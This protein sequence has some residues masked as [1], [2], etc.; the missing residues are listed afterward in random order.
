MSC[1]RLIVVLLGCSLA[2]AQSVTSASLKTS[3]DNGTNMTTPP[4]VKDLTAPE[5]LP[6]RA[7]DFSKG[8]NPET[9]AWE[10]LTQA[11]E[12]GRVG[13]RS[14]ATHALGLLKNNSRARILAEKG[15]TDDKPQVRAAAAEALG[16]MGARKSIPKLR[17]SL[18]DD[19]PSVALAAA[20]SLYQMHDRSSYEVYYEVLTRQRKSNKGLIAS[21]LATLEDPKKMAQLGFEEGIG[22]VPFA[23]I[24]WSAYKE[25]KK[26]DSSPVRAA[27]ARMLAEDPDPA[28]TVTL[29]KE[30]GDSSWIVRAAAVDALARRG[31]PKAL[32]TVESR[33]SDEKDVVSYTAAAATLRLL[34]AK[35]IKAAGKP[36]LKTSAAAEK[37]EPKTSTP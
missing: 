15:L 32:D 20:H 24:G 19:E 23:G 26:D 1:A 36:T 11:C 4:P 30:A 25:I 17:K 9:V 35:K 2:G 5:N 34:E 6:T 14:S 12:G 29:E 10:T 37:P 16:Q 13:E 8:Y 33:I 3:T 27:S 22:F 21:Q 18:N 7:P 28:M 31:D